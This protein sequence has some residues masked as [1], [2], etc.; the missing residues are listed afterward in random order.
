MFSELVDIYRLWIVPYQSNIDLNIIL[1]TKFM[2]IIENITVLK[3][4]C[5]KHDML[6]L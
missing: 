2:Q 5:N 1:N 3:F 4:N 6:Q